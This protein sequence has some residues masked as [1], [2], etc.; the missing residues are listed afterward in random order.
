[1]SIAV[2][3]SFKP[4]ARLEHHGGRVWQKKVA[5]LMAA[6]IQKEPEKKGPGTR[7]TLPGCIPSG[8]LPPTRLHLL[9]AHSAMNLSMNFN[10]LIKPLVIQ[11]PLYRATRWGKSLQHTSHPNHNIPTRIILYNL[12]GYNL[13]Y[14]DNSPYKVIYSQP[15]SLEL[16]H[17]QKGK[18]Y[19]M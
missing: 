15:P 5:Y 13:N 11:S 2:S 14:I 4:V 3:I 16:G 1:L 7:Y 10:P 12:K 19:S 17:H 18:Y 6:I 8:L 9:R